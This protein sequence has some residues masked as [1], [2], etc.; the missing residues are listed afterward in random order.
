MENRPHSLPGGCVCVP[1]PCRTSGVSLVMAGAISSAPHTHLDADDE[2][3]AFHA[4][5]FAD[6]GGFARWQ[7][8]DAT[9]LVSEASC[10]SC[11]QLAYLR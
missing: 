4:T 7:I 9:T 1:M 11:K 10:A 2:A 3:A 5:P 8:P 6:V